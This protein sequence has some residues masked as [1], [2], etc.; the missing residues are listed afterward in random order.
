MKLFR[1][2]DKM[3]KFC[4]FLARQC[5]KWGLLEHEEDINPLRFYFELMISQ[6]ITFLTLFLVGFIFNRVFETIYI[7]FYL[8]FFKKKHSRISC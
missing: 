5:Y 8:C 6:I 2:G 3:P 1:K 4:N 7:Y